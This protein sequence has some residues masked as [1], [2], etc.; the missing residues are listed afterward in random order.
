M[1]IS[2]LLA[3]IEEDFSGSDLPAA[4]KVAKDL[5]F[6]LSAK[7]SGRNV[8]KEQVHLALAGANLSVAAAEKVRQTFVEWVDVLVDDLMASSLP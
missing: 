2:D 7:I 3:W 8:D 1:N 4:K 6:L 5:A